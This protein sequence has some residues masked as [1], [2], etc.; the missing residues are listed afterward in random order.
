MFT[1]VN[2]YI[3]DI[4]CHCVSDENLH[5]KKLAIISLIGSR[6]DAYQQ[7]LLARTVEAAISPH[8]K[9]STGV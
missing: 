9:M 3:Y 1:M 8:I 5:D 4:S 7:M 6:L 2:I